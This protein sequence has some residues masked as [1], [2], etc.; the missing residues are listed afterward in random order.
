[1]LAT[2][3]NLALFRTASKEKKMVNKI[4]CTAY[5]VA[6]LLFASLHI[7]TIGSHGFSVLSVSAV[8]AAIATALY[9]SY[10]FGIIIG[11][12][13]YKKLLKK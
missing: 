2:E 8:F 10:G 7:Y 6:C 4:L 12:E 3:V 5:L 13:K 9:C 11:I 1:M